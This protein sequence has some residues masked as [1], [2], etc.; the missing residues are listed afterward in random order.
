[1]QF[2]GTSLSLICSQL[3]MIARNSEAIK[4][5]I[6]AILTCEFTEFLTE[7]SFTFISLI[8]NRRDLIFI[9][10]YNREMETDQLTCF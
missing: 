3:R 9:T 10:S 7:I 6:I 1:M 4:I 8:C 5:D 2:I